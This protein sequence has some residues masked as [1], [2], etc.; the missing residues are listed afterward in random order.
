VIGASTRDARDERFQLQVRDSTFLPFNLSVDH[1]AAQRP[2]PARLELAQILL[3]LC[4][5][6]RKPFDVRDAVPAWNDQP[7]R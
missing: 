5:D 6:L 2:V 4:V 7:Q 3:F 1:L